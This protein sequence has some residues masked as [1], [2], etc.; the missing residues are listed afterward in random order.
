M[1]VVERACSKCREK[2]RPKRSE[3][4]R[5]APRLY[6][7]P[8]PCEVSDASSLLCTPTTI[9][10]DCSNQCRKVGCGK[11]SRRSLSSIAGYADAHFESYGVVSPCTHTVLLSNVTGEHIVPGAGLAPEAIPTPVDGPSGIGHVGTIQAVP[12]WM[13][14]SHGLT[15]SNML[16]INTMTHSQP[17]QER[18]KR[19]RENCGPKRSGKY[20]GT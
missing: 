4:P 16:H 6:P 7:R 15:L 5:H 19:C 9:N 8:G 10:R 12:R 17:P 20:S 11:L 1:G 18:I 14:L 13:H 3:T 2:R